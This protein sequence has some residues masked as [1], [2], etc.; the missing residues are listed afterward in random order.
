MSP[1]APSDAGEA[2]THNILPAELVS[3]LFLVVALSMALT[4][5]LA[6]FGQKLSKTFDKGD[7]KARPGA[8]FR[9]LLLYR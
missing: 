6:E 5:F 7:M 4:P 2:I 9:P 1:W 3:I 8:C